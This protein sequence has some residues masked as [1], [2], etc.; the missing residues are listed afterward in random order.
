MNVYPIRV[1]PL[2]ER[3]EDIPPLAVHFMKLFGSQ[4][5]KPYPGI[6]EAEMEKL[7]AYSWPGNIRELSNIIERAVISGETGIRFA[8]LGT[9]D[10]NKDHPLQLTGEDLNLKDLEKKA[11][12]EALKK[13]NGV[14]GGKQGAAA[15]LGLKRTTLAHRIKKL[16]IKLKVTYM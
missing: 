4:S 11:I 16:G 3:R 15:L 7:C 14:I 12:L 6:T 13:S 8:E 10:K 2:R 9:K 5:N 1:P